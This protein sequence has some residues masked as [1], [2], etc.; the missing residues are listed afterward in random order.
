MA[1]T[2]ERAMIRFERNRSLLR[3]EFKNDTETR[4][5]LRGM[6]YLAVAA[7]QISLTDWI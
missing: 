7:T 1:I 4:T 5:R 3:R 6:H 2:N